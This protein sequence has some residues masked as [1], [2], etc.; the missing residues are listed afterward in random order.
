VKKRT[1]EILQGIES[2]ELQGKGSGGTSLLP[3]VQQT[4]TGSRYIP[5]YPHFEDGQELGSRYC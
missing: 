5:V 4:R 1:S 3:C 2:A